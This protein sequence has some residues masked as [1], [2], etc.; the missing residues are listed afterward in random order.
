[1]SDREPR[2]LVHCTDSDFFNFYSDT[3]AFVGD[4]AVLVA[5]EDLNGSTIDRLARTL[6]AYAES[7]GLIV[8]PLWPSHVANLG[9]L[10]RR[11]GIPLEDFFG[12]AWPAGA[13]IDS[14]SQPLLG[15]LKKYRPINTC[16]YGLPGEVLATMHDPGGA[17][18]V[19]LATS[20]PFR[21]G[22]IFLC[23]GDSLD[24]RKGARD[25]VEIALQLFRWSDVPDFGPEAD[26]PDEGE[27]RDRLADLKHEEEALS[28]RLIECA[29]SRR[30]I[31]SAQNSEL[32]DL[33]G[34]T[35]NALLNGTPYALDESHVDVG[36]ED[37]VFGSQD[38]SLTILVEIKGP[39]RGISVADVSQ[40]DTH[41]IQMAEVDEE[42][43]EETGVTYQALLVVNQH[44]GKDDLAQRR[45]SVAGEVVDAARLRH[46][47]VIRTWDLFELVRR[48]HAGKAFPI[49]EFTRALV[50]GGWLEV[51]PDQ[52]QLNQ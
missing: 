24:Q 32:V 49:Q 31:G 14:P 36:R 28:A 51:A 42:S 11:L 25:L 1:M 34:A 13:T 38:G 17:T 44:R 26:M 30:I 20:I 22:I 33:V 39:N 29:E 5:P 7:G 4:P 47:A 41:R 9:T 18:P 40:A 19:P 23:H 27:V 43:A 8:L 15:F 3:H 35:L 6:E 46:V 10:L 48:A 37:L 50:E 2:I 16:C 12:I 45:N 21:K 52:V